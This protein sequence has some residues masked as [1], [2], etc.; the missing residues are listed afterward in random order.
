MLK[1]IKLF[2]TV[3][4]LKDILIMPK[5]KVMFGRM[6]MQPFYIPHHTICFHLG[7]LNGYKDILIRFPNWMTFR[8]INNDFAY[9]WKYDEARF[10]RRGYFSI[11]V[12]GIALT[13][14]LE[15]PLDNED[16]YHEDEYYEFIL[17]FLSGTNSGDIKQCIKNMG[18]VTQNSIKYGVRKYPAMR[19]EWLLPRWH[20]IYDVAV[21]ELM[22]PKVA[23]PEW[24]LCA[25]TKRNEMRKISS[26]PYH[27]GT[28]D[29]LNVELG[30]RHHDIYHRFNDV[31]DKEIDVHM[32]AQGFFTS[33]GRWV[34][35]HEAAKIA[36]IAGQIDEPKDKLF[37]E[38]LY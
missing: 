29:I 18:I 6:S 25:A 16:K 11:V 31:D 2:R 9:K 22:R 27:D 8:V 14:Y 1:K 28:N 35:R 19:K 3:K 32:Y 30:Y 5:L 37:S 4:I 13:F 33:K 17:E 10:E 23:K 36:Y 24:I 21:E 26:K 15:A 20:R 34:D 12:F 7:K 38:D